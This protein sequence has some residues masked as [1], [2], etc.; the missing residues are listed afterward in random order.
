MRRSPT[1]RCSPARQDLRLIQSLRRRRAVAP[2]CCW[3]SHRNLPLSPVTVVVNRVFIQVIQ[4]IVDEPDC[5]FD[6]SDAPRV[7]LFT[8][9]VCHF[10][11]YGTPRR[12]SITQFMNARY[13]I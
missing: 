4:G 3:E 8:I 5:Q 11:V 1:W 10:L 13:A 7:F 6:L 12:F 2:R 9:A